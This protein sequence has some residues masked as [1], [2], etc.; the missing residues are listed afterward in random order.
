MADPNPIMKN[1]APWRAAMK[2]VS[3]KPGRMNHVKCKAMLKSGRQCGQ[4]AMVSYGFKVCGY[5]GGFSAL[6][7]LGIR[8]GRNKRWADDPSS[9]RI[10]KKAAR[11]LRYK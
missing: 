4:L 10:N 1:N 7:R 3:F 2:A 5:H 6:S 8:L 11:K 9:S